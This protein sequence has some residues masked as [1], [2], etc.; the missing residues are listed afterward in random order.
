MS[1]LHSTCHLTCP[2][3]PHTHTTGMCACIPPAHPLRN[4]G[5]QPPTTA[6]ARRR[7]HP[8]CTTCMPPTAHVDQQ[9]AP[10]CSSLW[11]YVLPRTTQKAVKPKVRP[12]VNISLLSAT[13][14][15][16]VPPAHRVAGDS[17]VE[18]KM[19]FWLQGRWY[20]FQCQWVEA[21][22]QKVGERL[23]PTQAHSHHCGE[24]ITPMHIHT[25]MR[26][27]SNALPW[28]QNTENRDMHI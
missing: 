25:H 18:A 12:S 7:H 14:T 21:G 17:R 20:C 26:T 9:P 2:S 6:H 19:L 23:S 15:N 27:H 10:T 24:C 3:A 16:S 8:L 22:M 1:C 5:V 11:K 13:C 28:C 4:T